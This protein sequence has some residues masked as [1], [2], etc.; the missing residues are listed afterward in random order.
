[1]R[2]HLQNKSSLSIESIVM[3]FS[4]IGDNENCCARTLLESLVKPEHSMFYYKSENKGPIP[5][6]LEKN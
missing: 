5:Y 3:S 1:M 2:L 6:T 4:Q